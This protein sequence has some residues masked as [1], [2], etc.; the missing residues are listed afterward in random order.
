[1]REFKNFFLLIYQFDLN[2]FKSKNFLFNWNYFHSQY[3]L[4]LQSFNLYYEKILCYDDLK[5]YYKKSLWKLI[6]FFLNKTALKFERPVCVNCYLIFMYQICKCIR[7]KRS[8]IFVY[9]IKIIPNK[10]NYSFI[11][12]L[13]FFF[14]TF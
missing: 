1:M 10:N 14:F 7:P 5:F 2:K 4:P 8:A 9:K 11:F 12:F 13:L 3:R 6:F